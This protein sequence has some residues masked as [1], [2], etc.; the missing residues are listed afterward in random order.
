MQEP[1]R[2]PGVMHSMTRPILA[3]LA[4]AVLPGLQAQDDSPVF[5]SDVRLVRVDAQVMDASNKAILNLQARDFRLIENSRN[6]QIKNFLAEDMPVDVLLLLDV[7]GSMRPNLEL[8]ERASNEAL[9]VLAAGDRVA[10]MTFDRGTKVRLPF[11]ENKQEVQS[12][13]SSLLD[14]E[15]FNGGTDILR[16][17]MDAVEYVEK[18]AR[19]DARRAIVIVTDDQTELRRDD[20]S[21]IASL[22]EADTVLSALL[23]PNAMRNVTGYPGGGRTGGG[24][25]IP[26]IPDILIGGGRR[27]PGGQRGPGGGGQPYPGGGGG[28]RTSSGGTPEIAEASGGDAINVGAAYAFRET[29]ERIRQRYALHFNLPPTARPSEARRVTVELTDAALTRYPNAQIRYRRTYRTPSTLPQPS[30]NAQDDEEVITQSEEEL[31]AETA[32]ANSNPSQQTGASTTQRQGRVVIDETERVRG[33]LPALREPAANPAWG[34]ASRTPGQGGA[35]P[36]AEPAPKPVWRTATE[37]DKAAAEE[38]E[39][40]PSAKS[41]P[42]KN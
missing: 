21:V 13:L 30:P 32:K 14:R 9:R 4:L 37:A 12:A 18:N 36:K 10:I 26:S 35:E 38:A 39:K 15:R 19:Q 20:D 41:A 34:G 24:I 40:E 27:Q 3:A 29:L 25:Y 8:L 6:R 11:R 7:S 22:A 28:S 33:P 1:A 5:R 42:K 2:G 31:E 23:A 16:G 17:M